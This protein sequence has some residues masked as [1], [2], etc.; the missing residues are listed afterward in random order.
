MTTNSILFFKEANNMM[1][2]SIEFDGA[3]YD[4]APYSF[5]ISDKL[6]KVDAFNEGTATV[7]EKC[8]KMYDLESE[9]IGKD[10]FESDFGKF[11]DVD[12]NVLNILWLKIIDAYEKPLT[13]FQTERRSQTLDDVE[14]D[15][16]L[17]VLETLGNVDYSIF[18][19]KG[20]KR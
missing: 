1:N 15:K 10:T 19:G 8:K 12:P 3:N 6:E 11:E 13:D 17:K 20:N 5:G 16:V 9:I 2:Y 4:L 18:T 7:R 14:A